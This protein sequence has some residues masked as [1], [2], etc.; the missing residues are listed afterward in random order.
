VT[1]GSFHS[2]VKTPTI[3][4]TVCDGPLLCST[5]AGTSRKPGTISLYRCYNAEEQP[6]FASNAPDCERLGEMEQ[7]LGYALKQ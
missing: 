3:A 6:H 4:L 7:L 1:S 2:L 5:R